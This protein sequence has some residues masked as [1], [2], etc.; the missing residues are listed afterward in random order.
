MAVKKGLMLLLGIILLSSLVVAQSIKIEFPIGDKINEN[1]DIQIKATL[2]DGENA[3]NGNILIKIKN[4]NDL[5]V[6]NKIISSKNITNINI[7]EN[8]IAGEYKIIASSNDIES[9]ESFF[10][11]SEE[12]LSFEIKDDVLT[13][14]NIGNTKYGGSIQIIIGDTPGTKEINLGVGE[15]ISL[16]LVAP[17]GLYEIK[18]VIDGKTAFT[19]SNVALKGKGLTGEVIGV[20]D[21]KVSQRSGITGGISPS[22]NSNEAILSYLKDSKFVYVFILVIFGAMILLAVERRYKKR[23]GK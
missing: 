2:Y 4:P 22:E 17:E 11:K 21:E 3:I 5:E 16:T 13:I 18:I 14:T 15:K 20:L 7:G 1:G 6:S 12:K 8:A 19:K 10:V 23:V 9:T